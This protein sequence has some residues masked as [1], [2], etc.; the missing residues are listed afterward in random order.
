M[1]FLWLA[2]HCYFNTN[3]GF[4]F[5][6]RLT[7]F[8][9]RDYRVVF[10]IK[11]TFAALCRKSLATKIDPNN[12]T[13]SRDDGYR[14]CRAFS[15]SLFQWKYCITKT[16]SSQSLWKDWFEVF[17]D[18]FILK[19]L[20]FYLKRHFWNILRCSKSLLQDLSDIQQKNS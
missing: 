6:H 20:Y 19:A 4:C 5:V 12:R 8:E 17:V 7:S 14:K 11:K 1:C 10:V 3:G 15:Y 18:L 13:K 9:P 16:K 2:G